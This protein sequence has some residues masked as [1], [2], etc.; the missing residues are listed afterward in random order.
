MEE[1]RTA[2]IADTFERIRRPLQWP[3]E[4]FR[5]TKVSTS[6]FAGYRFSRVRRTAVA[7]FAF[8]FAMKEGAIPGPLEPPEAVAYAFVRPRRSGLH[9]VLVRHRGSAV[10]RL[11]AASRMMGFPFEPHL[12]E[13]VAAVRHRSLRLVPREIF[14]LVASDFF[15][16]CYQPIRSSTFLE[17]VTKA[18]TRPGP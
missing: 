7:G 16:L 4:N 11:V 9:E 5:R 13:E 10:R 14:P 2:E 8:G 12:E 18:T 17:R 15:M 1:D 3:M 6:G